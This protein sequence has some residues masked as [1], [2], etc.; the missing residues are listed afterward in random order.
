[1]RAVRPNS[2]TTAT[3]VSRQ[4]VAHLGLDR[5]DGAVERAEQRREPAVDRAFVGMGVP[6]V[7]GERADARAI[8]PRQELRRGAR[9]FGEIGAHLRG[10]GRRRRALL[11]ASMPPARAIVGKSHALLEHARERRIGV[12]VEIEQ[13]H[14]ACRR[15]PAAAAAASTT[16]PAPARARPA[17]RS[18]RPRRLRA[19]AR[20]ARPAGCSAASARLSQPVSTAP[21][22]REAAFQH[23]LAVEMRALAVGRR[24]RMHDG[25]RAGLVEPVQVRHRRIEREEGIERQRRRL[26]VERERL[27][28]AQ[29]HPVRIA[30]RRDRRK[31]VERAAQHDHQ[32]ARIAALARARPS[33][34]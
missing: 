29:P 12:A 33:A 25:R 8:R 17:A 5:G 4:A 24:R 7:E 18:A 9:G 20:S 31:P 14:H 32:Q 11:L 19:R 27:V 28:A 22:L 10:A 13:P 3:T 34:R 6:A 30:D 1:M 15:S 2:V 16:A 21:G 23:V 26:A